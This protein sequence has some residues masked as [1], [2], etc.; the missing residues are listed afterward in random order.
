MVNGQHLGTVDWSPS[1]ASLHARCPRRFFYR[2]AESVDDSGA[3]DNNTSANQ[4]QSP[5]AKIGSVVHECID[6]QIDRWRRNERTSLQTAQATA[7]E[8]LQSYVTANA[9][10]LQDRFADSPDEF[11]EAEIARSLIRTAHTHLET[12]FQVIWPQLKNQQY[13]MH[14]D[15]RSFSLSGGTVW[16]RPDLCTRTSEGEFVVTDWKTGTP[17]SFSDASLQVQTYALW[18]HR[19]YEPELTRI[20][21]QL[22]YTRRGEFDRYRPD[23][24]MLE[25]VIDRI[26][27]DLEKWSPEAVK[28]AFPT[29]PESNKCQS[30]PY[31]QWCEDGQEIVSE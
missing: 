16:V 17:D 11:D 21:V 5:G 18:A 20:R 30:C 12:F 29:L 19:E 6:R 10:M 23:A 25:S 1:T 14:E 13:I 31:L 27:S 15:T 8:K 2:N 4:I 3:T 26:Q 28:S 9:T 7:I 24:E 22:V